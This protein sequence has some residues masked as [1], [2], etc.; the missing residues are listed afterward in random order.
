[1]KFELKPGAGTQ[2]ER[3]IERE[4]GKRP[5]A[6]KLEPTVGAFGAI[7]IYT[8]IYITIIII[9]I[10]ILII[11]LINRLYRTDARKGS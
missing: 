5:G 6:M 2:R 11:L 4:C 7:Y 1:M 8:Y 9:I 3:Q 10:I